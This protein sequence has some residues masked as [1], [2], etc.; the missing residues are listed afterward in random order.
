MNI[1][2]VHETLNARAHMILEIQQHFKSNKV[3]I[4]L[5]YLDSVDDKMLDGIYQMIK[6]KENETV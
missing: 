1:D 4:D 6:N 5:A 3:P 2:Q